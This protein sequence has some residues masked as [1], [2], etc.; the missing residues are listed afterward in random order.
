M[1]NVR[2]LLFVAVI[3][4][5]CS[6]ATV[7]KLRPVPVGDTGITVEWVEDLTVKE[8]SV[9][10]TENTKMTVYSIEASD[11]NYD[12]NLHLYYYDLPENLEQE[13]GFTPWQF[14]VRLMAQGN[15][16]PEF[17]F[18]YENGIFNYQGLSAVSM[19]NM[20]KSVNKGDPFNLQRAEIGALGIYGASE[21]WTQAMIIRSDLFEINGDIVYLKLLYFGAPGM[22]AANAIEKDFLSRYLGQEVLSLGLWDDYPF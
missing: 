7:D 16:C 1:K 19:A 14:A 21:P 20:N 8:S 17:L 3:F 11:D 12:T 15:I 2:G 10:L 9:N 5:L 6:C 4:L 22:R 18:A 13:T